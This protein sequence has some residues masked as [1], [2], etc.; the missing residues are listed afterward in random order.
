MLSGERHGR[1]AGF[2]LVELLVVLVLMGVVGGI[3]VNAIVTA[4]RSASTT[5]AR[6]DAIHELEV[7]LQRVGRELRAANPI[8]LDD[9]G[10]YANRL[11]AEFIRGGDAHIV[12]FSLEDG[13][14]H[15]ELTQTTIVYDI[16]A[17]AEGA[18]LEDATIRS[19]S[20][21]LVTI[22]DNGSD[23]VFRYFDADGNEL[24]CEVDEDAGVTKSDC[25]AVYSRAHQIGLRLVR[26]IPDGTDV[27]AE[28]RLNVRNMR[29]RSG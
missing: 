15:Q 7:S 9:S 6:L 12:T 18:T 3:V 10:D 23:P 25:D 19:T 16:S 29:Y 24:H 2:T 14:E 5:T 4:M 27:R 1:E 26:E 13:E 28:T 11:G 17:L 21:R 22:V 20:T 8:Y